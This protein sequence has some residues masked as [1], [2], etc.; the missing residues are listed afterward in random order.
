MFFRCRT[1][2]PARLLG[3]QISHRSLSTDPVGCFTALTE[4]RLP[5]LRRLAWTWHLWRLLPFSSCHACLHQAALDG[6]TPNIQE[7]EMPVAEVV[8][9]IIHCISPS[10]LQSRVC[11]AFAFLPVVFDGLVV[12]A[13]SSLESEVALWIP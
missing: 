5:G 11:R 7:L 2:Q 6:V 4:I 1:K 12:L 8:V 9:V 3:L 10:L 13:K